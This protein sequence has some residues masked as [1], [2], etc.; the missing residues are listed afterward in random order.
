MSLTTPSGEGG[1]FYVQTNTVTDPISISFIDAPLD[2][3]LKCEASSTTSRVDVILH[4]TYEGSF[5]ASPSFNHK[6]NLQF[7]YAPDPHGKDKK[8]YAW[9]KEDKFNHRMV[10]F[11]SWKSNTETLQ[12]QDM[13]GEYGEITLSSVNAPISLT[14]SGN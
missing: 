8:I 11:T 14:I 3:V 12:G 1:S 7:K 2:S 10:G 9:S 13:R 5:S 4:P 6:A